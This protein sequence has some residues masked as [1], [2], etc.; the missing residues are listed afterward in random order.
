VCNGS[1]KWPADA[2]ALLC[3]AVA[4]ASL[5]VQSVRLWWLRGAP[6]RRMRAAAARGA[7]GEVRAEALL[8]RLGYGITARQA[9]ERW[10]IAVDGEDVAVTVRA[11]YLVTRGGR[12]FVA[13]VKTGE[14]APRAEHPPTRRQLLE[15]RHAFAVDG[16]LLVHAEAGRVQEVEFP[17]AARRG[18]TGRALVV[19]FLLGAACA[20]ALALL[21]SATV[22]R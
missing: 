6:R 2:P 15:Y 12:R 7:A 11:D 5:V 10:V 13:E 3:A 1:V 20:V 21:F 17:V 14:S 22:R 18:A 4:L 19:A 16:V 8:E 9:S